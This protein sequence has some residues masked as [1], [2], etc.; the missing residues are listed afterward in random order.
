MLPLDRAIPR[1]AAYIRQ[2]PDGAKILGR[3]SFNQR[4]RGQ[5]GP[6]VLILTI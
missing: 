6:D 1:L 5:D 2:A 4:D 3:V